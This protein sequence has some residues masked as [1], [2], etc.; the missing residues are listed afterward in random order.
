LNTGGKNALMLQKIDKDWS[1]IMKIKFIFFIATA[2]VVL[3]TVAAKAENIIKVGA[4][5]TIEEG[6]KIKNAVVIDGQ[7]TVN[8][9]VEKNVITIGGSV[10]LTSKAVVRGNILCIGGVI[11]RGRDAQVFGNTKEINSS[12]ITEA[13]SSFFRGDADEWSAVFTAIFLYFYAIIFIMAVLM[14]IIFPSFLT[15]LKQSIQKN[16]AKS[17]LCGLFIALMIAPFFIMLVISLI[18][19]YLIPLIFAVLIA[20]FLL[21]YIAAGAMLGEFILTKA[22]HGFRKSLIKE[23]ILGLVLLLII[24]WIPYIGWLIKLLVIIIGLGGV[25]VA[26]L[27]RKRR[28]TI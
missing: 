13:I 4:D 26:A 10:V 27:N 8:G 19:I 25:F 20:A 15:A 18:G 17:F 22:N 6:M 24:G 7:I 21:G 1:E 3:S 14:A 9:L 11:A 5:V 28:V 23:T 16:K 2:L 12:N